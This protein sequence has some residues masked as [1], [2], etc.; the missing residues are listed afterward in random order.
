MP[1]WMTRR[2]EQPEARA[3][4]PDPC[5]DRPAK[6]I[7]FADVHRCLPRALTAEP[8]EA[9][10]DQR[11]PRAVDLENQLSTDLDLG[12]PDRVR[13]AR[14]CRIGGGRTQA[15]T[16]RCARCSGWS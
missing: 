7:E 14:D 9:H 16:P 8:A 4:R 12:L 10:E 6:V 11:E 3:S 15:T 1:A 5:R 2:L 13:P